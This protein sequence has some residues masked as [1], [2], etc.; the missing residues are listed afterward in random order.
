M[1]L[2]REKY[3]Y[4][5]TRICDYNIK[6][7]S[8][9]I[10]ESKTECVN[11]SIALSIAMHLVH[12]TEGYQFFEDAMEAFE[13]ADDIYRKAVAYTTPLAEK[14]AEFNK[15]EQVIY[16]MASG[17]AMGSA[18][19]FSICNL[20]E[21]LQLHSPTTN[22]CEFFHGPFE[23]LDKRTSVFVLVSE[24][25]VRPADERVIR[26]LKTYGGDKVYLLDAKELGIT[27]IKDTVSEYF[28]HILFSPILNN[29]YMRALSKKIKKD[30][31]TRRYMWKVEY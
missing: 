21:M 29:V 11:S 18:Y 2:K 9:A 7:E 16:V 4:D 23:I 22:C 19:I 15:E 8:I 24:G 28:N 14:W 17:P 10:D 30:Y 25:R 3:A 13:I 26:F 12:K 5:M 6:Y 1:I 31:S 27:R 20:E